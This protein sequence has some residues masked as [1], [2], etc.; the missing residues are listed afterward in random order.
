MD[1]HLPGYAWDPLS[2][3]KKPIDLYKSPMW[4]AGY[5][6]EHITPY[7][8]I[9]ASLGCQFKYKFCMINI[10]NRNDEQEIGI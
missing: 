7:A 8:A 2:Y 1:L 6:E 5:N 10:I 4:H 9:Q 3:N